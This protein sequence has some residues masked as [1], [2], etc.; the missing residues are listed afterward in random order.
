MIERVRE[1]ERELIIM[2]I[3]GIKTD[4]CC[5][6]GKQILPSKGG[7]KPTNKKATGANVTQNSDMALTCLIDQR[8]LFIYNKLGNGSFGVVKRGEWV[9]P[10]GTKV[11]I[12][13]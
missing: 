5:V 9:T 6:F 4:F 11:Y 3:F 7:E 12:T 8:N 10:S 1:K 13:F 2:K